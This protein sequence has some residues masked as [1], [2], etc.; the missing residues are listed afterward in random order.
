MCNVSLARLCFRIAASIGV[1][2]LLILSGCTTFNAPYQY[3]AEGSVE[4]QK[5]P[6][7][8]VVLP[9]GALINE[10]GITFVVEHNDVNLSCLR[11]PKISD[12]SFGA[13]SSV[14]WRDIGK[15]ATRIDV[16][17]CKANQKGLRSC[18][19]KAAAAA[20]AIIKSNSDWAGCVPADTSMEA[21]LPYDARDSL[22]EDLG[23][24]FVLENESIDI[25]NLELSTSEAETFNEVML[26]DRVAPRQVSSVNVR[27]G[28]KICVQ[29]EQSLTGGQGDRSRL[30]S[31]EHCAQFAGRDG[32]HLNFPGLA[33]LAPT[34]YVPL[35]NAH[36]TV[37][38]FGVYGW[39]GIRSHAIESLKNDFQL[40]VYF[41]RMQA[42]GQTWTTV[43]HV[44]IIID[45]TTKNVGPL[46]LLSEAKRVMPSGR[47]VKLE[48]LCGPGKFSCFL[49]LDRPYVRI[50]QTIRMGQE[51][52]DAELGMNLDELIV[53]NSL[54]A[55]VLSRPFRGR[56]IPVKGN[57]VNQVPLVRGDTLRALHD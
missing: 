8:P 48:D 11:L 18:M 25:T 51:L 22:E 44:P 39:S 14:Y 50:T 52:I 56:P 24:T 57:A 9:P 19:R 12:K 27:P 38:I 20:M 34:L 54:P 45:G 6:G 30:A 23:F 37:A 32:E 41:P 17:S 55:V 36:K 16:D 28:M 13:I 4:P 10:G 47:Q 5:P 35:L 29:T 33:H 42:F 46:M 1:M 15:R 3:T 31:P 49:F 21:S 53:V 26:K 2:C 40:T 7:K 43:N